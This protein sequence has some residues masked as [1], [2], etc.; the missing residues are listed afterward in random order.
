MPLFGPRRNLPID[1]HVRI[2]RDSLQAF[3]LCQWYPGLHPHG[4][5]GG[6]VKEYVAGFKNANMNGNRSY[7]DAPHVTN[8]FGAA[9]QFAA[10]FFNGSSVTMTGLTYSGGSASGP[11]NGPQPFPIAPPFSVAIWVRPWTQNGVIWWHGRQ[12]VGTWYAHYIGYSNASKSCSANSVDNNVFRSASS[13]SNALLD[14]KW[15][16]VC[17]VW[18]STTDRRIYVNGV[19]HAQDTN[20]SNPDLSSGSLI[21][22]GAANA[23]ASV[24]NYWKGHIFDLRMYR[25]A[26][27]APEVMAIYNPLTRFDLYSTDRYS[28]PYPGLGATFDPTS[29]VGTMTSA[30]PQFDRQFVPV[31]YF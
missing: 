25:R 15:N 23:N 11:Q 17:A 29:V 21:M 22:V 19:F 24:D 20:T 14:Q 1:T 13:A 31:P 28:E 7:P 18:H 2:N 27:S 3:G 4:A 6:L 26:L 30:P 10:P 16:H 12:A 8:P 5:G 9:T